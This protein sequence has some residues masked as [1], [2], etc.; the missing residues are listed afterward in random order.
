MFVV[1]SFDEATLTFIG[2][3]ACTT[4]K[5]LIHMIICKRKL[6]LEGRLWLNSMLRPSPNTPIMKPSNIQMFITAKNN[7]IG[8]FITGAI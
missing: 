6:F 2:T 1:T 8:V 7:T 3:I 4:N 5:G